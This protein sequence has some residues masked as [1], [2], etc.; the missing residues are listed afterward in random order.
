MKKEKVYDCVT[1]FQENLH[2]E[3]RIN[4]LKD[5]VDKF[6][7]CES[8][9]D[10]RGNE[11]KI[12]FSRNDYP[13]LKDKIKHIVVKE[14]FPKDNDPWKNQAIQREHILQHIEELKDDDY[15]MF[16]DPDEIPNPESVNK[17]NLKKKFGI[18]HQNIYSYKFNILNNNESPWEGTR[19]CKKKYLKSIDWLRHKVV[20]KNLKYPFWR[21]DREKSIE[22]IKD[23]GWHFSYLLTPEQIVNKFKSLAETSWD[24]EKY[25]D[26]EYIKKRIEE[27]K[28]LFERGHIYESVKIDKSYPEYITKNIKKY[29]RWI[30]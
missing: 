22:I 26:L 3:L 11:K 19:V 4:I 29:S 8:K 12:N 18:F 24:N 17:L 1:F 25:L 15:I 5:V 7:I 10:H 27:K 9:Y 2:M 16:S 30:D 21:V 28:D 20:T 23:G 13:E 14:M 6:I